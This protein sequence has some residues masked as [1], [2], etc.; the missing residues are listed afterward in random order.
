MKWLPALAALAVCSGCTPDAPEEPA[1]PQPVSDEGWRVHV[2]GQEAGEDHPGSVLLTRRAE[3]G[4]ARLVLGCEEGATQAY[5]EWAV[6]LGEDDVAVTYRVDD[7]PAQAARW[8]IS[9]D[10]EAAGLW[11]DSTSVPFLRALLGRGRLTTEVTPEGGS[12]IT[13]RFDLRGLDSLVVPV[14]ERCGWRG[15]GEARPAESSGT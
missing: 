5:V 11:D 7:A 14:Q 3:A 12:P 10:R 2:A 4:G 1:A 13:S 8:R 6:P 9:D 15:D